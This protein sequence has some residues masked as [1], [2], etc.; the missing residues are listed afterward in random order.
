MV[1]CIEENSRYFLGTPYESRTLDQNDTESLVCINSAFDCV[2]FVEYV[3]ALS[4]YTCE[5]ILPF[6]GYLRQLRYRN[7]VIDGYGSRL[8]YTSEWINQGIALGYFSEITQNLGGKSIKKQINFMTKNIH[9]YPSISRDGCMKDIQRVEENLSIDSYFQ[10]SKNE[11][12]NIEKNLQTGDII[13]ITTKIDGLDI[14]H[15]GFIIKDGT[16]VHLL[17][18]S[19]TLHKITISDVPLSKYLHRNPKQEGIRVLRIIK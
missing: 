17:H 5:G 1:H 11:V 12:K 13:A 19:E 8:H 18:A 3:L 7:G 15:L 2:T 14:S 9:L 16:A 4:L 6:E 10:V